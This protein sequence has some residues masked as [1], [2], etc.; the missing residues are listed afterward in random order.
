MD[1]RSALGASLLEPSSFP[2]AT[3]SPYVA[4]ASGIVVSEQ[5]RAEFIQ[6]LEKALT[7]DVDKVPERRLANVIAQRRAKLLLERIDEH[8]IE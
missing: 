1:R 3:A 7:V 5:G 2:A 8:F 6:L 4:L